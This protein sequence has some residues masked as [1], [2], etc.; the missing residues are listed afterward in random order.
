MEQL[1]G[2]KGDCGFV[3]ERFRGCLEAG[4]FLGVPSDATAVKPIALIVPCPSK[5]GSGPR[6]GSGEVTAA[7]QEEESKNANFLPHSCFFPFV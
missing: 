1:V 3:S 5:G 6:K 7:F 4:H 2:P